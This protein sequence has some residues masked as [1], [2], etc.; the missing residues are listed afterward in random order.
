MSQTNWEYGTEEVKNFKN[1]YLQNKEVEWLIEKG[2]I[3]ECAYFRGAIGD[4]YTYYVLTKR[5]KNTVDIHEVPTIWEYSTRI[6]SIPIATIKN[7]ILQAVKAETKSYYNLGN[8]LKQIMRQGI[9]SLINPFSMRYCRSSYIVKFHDKNECAPWVNMKINLET[10]DLVNKPNKQAKQDYNDAITSDKAQRKRNYEANKH[11]REALARYKAAGGDTTHSRNSWRAK[12][13][14]GVENINWDMIPMDDIFKHRNVT[15]RTNILNH[16]GI[17]RILQTLKYDVVDIDFVNGGEYR[18][19]NVTIPD[20][21][22]VNTN[23]FINQEEYK[24]LYLEMKN[25]STGESHFEGIANVGDW[26]GPR[27]A[28]V[29]AALA[30]RDGDASMVDTGGFSNSPTSDDYVPPI[31]IT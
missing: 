4:R 12:V 6:G 3:R 22:D 28:T 24:G 14:E 29:K 31:K 23:R 20:L 13:G 17:N 8:S 25:P 10:G 2:K 1:T 21:T 18:L 7:K 5:S 16:Y 30:W 15:F 19:L 11:N 27:E 26:G 9:N